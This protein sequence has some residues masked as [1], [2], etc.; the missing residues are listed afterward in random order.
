MR[1]ISLNRH[2]T[3]DLIACLCIWMAL[4]LICF[5]FLPLFGV[6]EPADDW[7]LLSFGLGAVGSLLF[8]TS[9]QII[10]NADQRRKWFLRFL[11]WLV[12][13][14]MAWIGVVGIA[15]PLLVVAMQAVNRVFDHL[16]A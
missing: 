10:L 8:A 9:S 5:G 3:R 12:G 14:V 4:T 6:I 15:F 16:L 2:T 1:Q 7:F 11:Q 13:I